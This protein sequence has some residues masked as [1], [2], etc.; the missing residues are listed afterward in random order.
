MFM[1]AR[2]RGGD[3]LLKLRKNQAKNVNIN[4]FGGGVNIAII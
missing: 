1:N 2:L 4:I 3:I